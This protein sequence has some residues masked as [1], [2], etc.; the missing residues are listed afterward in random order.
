M[1]DRKDLRVISGPEQLLAKLTPAEQRRVGIIMEAV[2]A[3]SSKGRPV[4]LHMGGRLKHEGITHH[5]RLVAD[6]PRNPSNSLAPT[7][8]YHIRESLNNAGLSFQDRADSTIAQPYILREHEWTLSLDGRP[9]Y[10]SVGINPETRGE[11]LGRL[12]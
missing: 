3:F 11:I 4:H 8:L 5:I 1:P 7:L 12:I 6:L 9:L 10:I 2:Q